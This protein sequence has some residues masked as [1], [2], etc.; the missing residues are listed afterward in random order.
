MSI[1]TR[2][3]ENTLQDKLEEDM[4]DENRSFS[5]VSVSATETL[6][7]PPI[8]ASQIVM[9]AESMDDVPV[10]AHVPDT[11]MLDQTNVSQ[12][13]LSHEGEENVCIC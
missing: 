10:Q 4:F 1:S 6:I 7:P 3:E 9:A 11:M 5:S 12:H 13:L 8:E 2:E